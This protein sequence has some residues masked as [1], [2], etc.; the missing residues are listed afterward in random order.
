LGDRRVEAAIFHH[1]QDLLQQ[2]D[3]I[4]PDRAAGL[5]VG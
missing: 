5:V 2:I 1:V 3:R 4:E